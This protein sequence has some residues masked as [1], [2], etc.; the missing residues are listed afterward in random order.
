MVIFKLQLALSFDS[1]GGTG[2]DALDRRDSQNLQLQS[3]EREQ[4]QL[5]QRERD[6]LQEQQQ[7]TDREQLKLPQQRE[8]DSLLITQANREREQL[9]VP[10]PN[11]DREQLQFQQRER[12]QQSHNPIHREKLQLQTREREQLHQLQSISN[13]L[14][15]LPPPSSSYHSNY[16]TSC[17]Q[18]S[19]NSS[20]DG[21]KDI[22]YFLFTLISYFIKYQLTFCKLICNCKSIYGNFNLNFYGILFLDIY[23]NFFFWR[24]IFSFCQFFLKAH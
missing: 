5:A 16:D 2:V 13:M 23:L 12:E 9:Q 24:E 15:D 6:Q 4:L 8:R 20:M 14:L 19:K 11:R 22:L 7:Q 21:E 18:S 1:E 10:H 3:R 17:T